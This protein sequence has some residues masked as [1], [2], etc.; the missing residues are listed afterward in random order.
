MNGLRSTACWPRRETG[1]AASWRS[2]ASPESARRRCSTT[3]RSRPTRC[4]C[5]ERA[6]SSRNLK[7]HSPGLP[8]SCDRCCRRSTESRILRLLHSPVLWRSVQRD[9]PIG[10]PSEPPRSACSRRAP[11]RA[12]WSCWSTTLIGSTAPP[13]RRFGSR[14]GVSSRIRS[15]WSFAA[16]E[17]ATSLLDGSDLRVLRVPG[18]ARPDAAALLEASDLTGDVAERLI[19]TAGGNPLALL[20]LASDGD[21]LAAAPPDVPV[22]ISTDIA[23]AFLR[24]FGQ[25]PDPTRRMLVVAARATTATWR[26]LNGRPRHSP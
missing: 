9:R 17:G 23:T 11:K 15:R 4:A 21:R 18:L 8:I 16:R 26:S 3:S 6:G 1:A 12:R 19:R 24:R 25:L 14:P 2:S 20:A 10:S 5:C 7:F 13:L 22:P